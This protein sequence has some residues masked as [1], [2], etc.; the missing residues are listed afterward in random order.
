MAGLK[1][2]REAGRV[3]RQPYARP[4]ETHCCLSSWAR[5]V[6]SFELVI[7]WRGLDAS[8]RDSVKRPVVVDT[9]KS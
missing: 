5:T 4:V 7:L 6:N 9:L 8:S 2:K 1:R 3:V